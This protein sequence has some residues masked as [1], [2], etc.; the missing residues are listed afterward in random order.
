[1]LESGE[2]GSVVV[3]VGATLLDAM[4]TVTMG[5][6]AVESPR[7]VRRVHTQ[8]RFEMPKGSA[9]SASNQGGQICWKNVN[10]IVIIG[11]QFA[12]PCIAFFTNCILISS[13]TVAITLG[14]SAQCLT[15]YS[16]A[17]LAECQGASLCPN[18]PADLNARGGRLPW[19]PRRSRV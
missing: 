14:F 4:G 8:T 1:M 10:G 17:G 18:S 11:P 5:V 13:C 9:L 15:Y 3:R 12:I 19:R 2:E 16:N 6:M 7:S